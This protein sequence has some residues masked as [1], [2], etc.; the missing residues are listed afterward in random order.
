MIDDFT[1]MD[2]RWLLDTFGLRDRCGAFA[3]FLLQITAKTA[4]ARLAARGCAPVFPRNNKVEEVPRAG[5]PRSGSPQIRAGFAALPYR[6]CQ[7]GFLRS[8]KALGPSM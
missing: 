3:V 8:A 6:F 5:A 7:F 1:I 4:G 2:A